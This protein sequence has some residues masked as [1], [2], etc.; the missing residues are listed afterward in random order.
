[1]QSTAKSVA[2]T[3]SSSV[4]GDKLKPLLAHME[5]LTNKL[6]EA[7]RKIKEIRAEKRM[8]AAKA[9][10]QIKALEAEN[11][12]KTIEAEKQAK[13]LQAERA[14]RSSSTVEWTFT[15]LF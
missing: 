5:E 15:I 7:E 1:M 3:E 8:E 13:A 14:L 10:T 2:S 11:Q 12:I 9:E 4:D 6:S